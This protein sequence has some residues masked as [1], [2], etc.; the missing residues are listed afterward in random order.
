MDLWLYSC[1]EKRGVKMTK[2][3]ILVELF[4]IGYKEQSKLASYNRGYERFSQKSIEDAKELLF[5]MMHTYM[6]RLTD[7]D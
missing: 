2:I 7:E 5:K 1:D 4:T 6:Q 3:E